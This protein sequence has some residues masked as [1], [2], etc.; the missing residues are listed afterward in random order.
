MNKFLLKFMTII[1]SVAL[2]FSLVAC[3]EQNNDDNVV[4]GTFEYQYVE[5]E[6]DADGGYY[7]ITGYN[8]NSKDV[9]NNFKNVDK[10][11][12]ELE[13]PETAEGLGVTGDKAT[14]KVK[15]IGAAAFA[16]K[17]ILKK[18][19][20]G[21]NIETIGLG[22]FANCHNLEEITVPFV[23]KSVDAVNKERVFAHLFTTTDDGSG[24]NSEVAV[25]LYSQKDYGGNDLNSDEDLKYFVPT[26]LK[27]VTVLGGEIKASAF[28]GFTKV[29]EIVVSSNVD[30]IG[31]H[32]FYNC[33]ALKKVTLPTSVKNIYQYAFSSCTALKTLPFDQNSQIELIGREAFSGCSSIGANSVSAIVKV[34][35]FP[36]TLQ[37]IGEKAF[38]NCSSIRGL[39]LSLTAIKEIDMSVFENCSSIERL[40]IKDGVTVRTGAFI[41]CTKLTKDAIANYD[42]LSVDIDA[43]DFK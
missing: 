20:I 21:T 42:K 28:Y 19:T 6:D 17:T 37:F 10:K 15:E 18:V 11:Y 33:S 35:T 3:D 4:T 30:Y 29:E 43:F 32:A 38:M 16:S 23:G 39:D 26:A 31:S 1:L 14:L 8:V 27:K 12:R 5:D 22:A 9:E 34:E 25:K 7:K 41:G 40:S 36:Q 24:L 2:T 13:I